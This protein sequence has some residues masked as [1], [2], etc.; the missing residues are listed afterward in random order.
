MTLLHQIRGEFH[1]I[2]IAFEQQQSCTLLSEMNQTFQV[3]GYQIKHSWECLIASLYKLF[4]KNLRGKVCDRVCKL[5][6]RWSLKFAFFFF[7]KF[8]LISVWQ[9]S[10][11]YSI[12]L[13]LLKF[14]GEGYWFQNSGSITIVTS[15]NLMQDRMRFSFCVRDGNYK[16]KIFTIYLSCYRLNMDSCT[17]VLTFKALEESLHYI[18]SIQIKPLR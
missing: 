17:V 2:S 12:G 8:I 9:I 18:V 6:Y 10:E 7:Y 16:A 3:F 15:L 14:D 13:R 4:M 11:F 5:I 1:L